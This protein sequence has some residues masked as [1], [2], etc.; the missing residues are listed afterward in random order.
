VV[1]ILAWVGLGL[2]GGLVVGWLWG[3]RGRTLAGDA[4][5]AVLGAMLGGFIASVTLG[6]DISGIDGTS[7]IVAAV[8]AALLLLV[9][10]ALPATDIFE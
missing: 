7:L 2:L 10:H 1:S 8:G 4:V 9:L 5:V 6:L 3:G